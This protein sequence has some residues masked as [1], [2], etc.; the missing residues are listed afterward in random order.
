MIAATMTADAVFMDALLCCAEGL[1][2]GPGA[3]GTEVEW[4]TRYSLRGV[5]APFAAIA[6]IKTS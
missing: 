4:P 6:E 5:A 1:K 3:A 2:N